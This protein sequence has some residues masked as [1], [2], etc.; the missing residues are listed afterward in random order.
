CLLDIGNPSIAQRRHR[1]AF[2]TARSNSWRRAG[3]A[4]TSI[5]P[6]LSFMKIKRST[7]RS[8]PPGANTTPTSPA[9]SAGWANRAACAKAIAPLAQFRAPCTSV[10]LP[11]AAAALSTRTTTSGSSTARSPLK[12]PPRKAAT[13][14]L[15]T[16]RWQV[17]SVLTVLSA[18]CTRRRP[19]LASCLAP[20]RERPTIGD[21]LEGHGKHVVHHEHE[22]LGGGEPVEY[23]QQ[24]EAD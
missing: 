10:G 15:T 7:L 12:S 2:R 23:H 19:L 11:E 5:S 6:I 13:K 3:S 9:T 18:P 4:T 22:A 21:L 8:R 20:A 14:A 17:S 24:S 1:Q 16:S